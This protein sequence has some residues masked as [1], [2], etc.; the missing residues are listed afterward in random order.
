MYFCAAFFRS[1]FTKYGYT[2]MLLQSVL[3]LA[4]GALN[5]LIYLVKS[6][7]FQKRRRSVHVAKVGTFQSQQKA[8]HELDR[9]SDAYTVTTHH[10]DI[11][12]NENINRE[13]GKL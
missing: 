3:L 9:H 5:Q 11:V 1:V 4:F 2:L 7:L 13:C 12:G 10:E 8:V 6:G